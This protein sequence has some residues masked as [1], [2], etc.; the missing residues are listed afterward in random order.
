MEGSRVRHGS[1]TPGPIKAIDLRSWARH[2]AFL[3]LLPL[4][5]KM[6][7]MPSMHST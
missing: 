4:I 1:S 5:G 2:V 6:G 7:G 3:K